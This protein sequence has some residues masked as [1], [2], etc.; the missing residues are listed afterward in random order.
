MFLG[1]RTLIQTASTSTAVPQKHLAFAVGPRFCLGAPLARLEATIAV[2][3]FAT[4]RL[5]VGFGS[6][7]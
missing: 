2:R 6:L 7:G 3:A 5:V 1:A 4:Q